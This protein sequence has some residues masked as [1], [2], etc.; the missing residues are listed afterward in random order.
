MKQDLIL[1]VTGLTHQGEGIARLPDGLVIFIPGVIPGEKV[2]V[3]IVQ[4]QKKFARANLLKILEQ[5]AERTQPACPIYNNCGGCSWQ[6]LDYNAQLRYKT[7]RVQDSLVRLGKIQH[8]NVLATLGMEQPWSYRNKLHLQAQE[9]NGQIKLGYFEQ[10][11]HCF[12]PLLPHNCLLV[13]QEL[14]QT[15][16]LVENLLNK[17]QI[18]VFDWKHKRGIIRHIV[19]RKA[20]ATGEIM[21]VIVTGSGKWIN[22][23]DFAQDLKNR[24]LTK[25]RLVSIIRNINTASNRVV[26]GDKNII[27]SG[28]ATIT[29]RLETGQSAELAFDISP[30]AFLQINHLQTQ[31]LYRKVIQFA[32]LTGREKVLD[33]YCGIGTIALSLA[34]LAAA[35]I[36]LEIVPQAVANAKSNAQRNGITNAEFYQGEAGRLLLLL[37]REGY[38]PDLVV[39]DPPRRGCAPEL[40]KVLVQMAVPRII[41]ISCDPGT[42]ARDLSYLCSNGYQVRE[43]QPVD[44]FPHSGHVETVVRLQRQNP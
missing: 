24:D 31:V 36:G 22:Q 13:D 1:D 35:V 4:R 40:L 23:D 14:N 25:N 39:L 26:L 28:K 19:L 10:G 17:Y 41:Y 27:L 30:N 44:M 7:R 9:I 21:V 37:C 38:Q 8:I 42:L 32:G 18:P 33:I 3:Q 29:E 34:A 6:H 5:V 15:A 12:I 43:V 11:S 16:Q 2:L 20:I